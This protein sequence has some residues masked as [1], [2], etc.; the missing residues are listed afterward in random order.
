MSVPQG[1]WAI[2][3]IEPSK[4]LK[5]VRSAYAAKLK[6]I[7]VDADPAAFMALRDAYE[8]AQDYVRYAA[9]DEE[10]D[11]FGLDDW[12]DSEAAEPKVVIHSAEAAGDM[13][14]SAPAEDAGQRN[15]AENPWTE[16]TGEELYYRIADI[17]HDPEKQGQNLGEEEYRT[18]QAATQDF[19]GWLDRATIDDA[20]DYEFAL[21]HLMAATIPRS[22]PMLDKIPAYFGWDNAADNYDFP[23]QVADILERRDANQAITLLVDPAHRLHDAFAALTSPVET[24]RNNPD[25][26]EKVRELIQSAQRYHPSLQA[27]FD[28]DRVAEWERTLKIGTFAP[29]TEKASESGKN[30]WS[31]WWVFL[32]L[33]SL[34]RFCDAGN[35]PSGADAPLDISSPAA[36]ADLEQMF[37]TVF[38]GELSYIEAKAVAPVFATYA[39]INW[40]ATKGAGNISGQGPLSLNQTATS[41]VYQELP[42]ANADDLRAYWQLWSEKAQSQQKLGVAQC[43]DFVSRQPRQFDFPEA[44]KKR[45]QKMMAHIIKTYYSNA[46][47]E[48][49]QRPKSFSIS[50]EIIE[51]V[52]DQSK[53][54]EA[55]VRSVFERKGT[56]KNECATWIVFTKILSESKSA[57]AVTLMKAI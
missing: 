7:D 52:I 2:L 8:A 30:W 32:I 37:G 56:P 18:I 22:D 46:S 17:L 12:D 10:D 16:P 53:L 3:G 21:A 31:Y 6:T 40:R 47:L 20:R 41:V 35:K 44:I 1:F 23:P 14:Q 42:K 19:I 11:D 26:R 13:A 33:I 49:K 55:E 4:E 43:Q 36:Q 51:Q 50:G 45:D 15:D 54:S 29:G 9:Y 28:Y 34:A 24:K 27:A 25:L 39:E 38:G 57:D 48:Y 5:V